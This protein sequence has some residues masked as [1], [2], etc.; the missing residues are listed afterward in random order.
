[1]VA[2][3][4]PNSMSSL[5]MALM[6]RPSEVPPVV[7]N[8]ASTPQISAMASRATS[9]SF[10]PELKTV[11]RNKTDVAREAIAEI[12]GVGGRIVHRTGGTSDGRFIKAI[13]KELIE[14]GPSNA[15]IHQINETYV[16]RYSEAVGS[17]WRYVETFV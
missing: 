5:A 11:G 1:M 10:R 14:L 4:G 17:I 8:S 7:D 2:L 9:V 13:A 16:G 3:D 6:K 15:T 12:C